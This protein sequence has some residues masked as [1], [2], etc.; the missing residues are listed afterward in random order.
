MRALAA[1]MLD[2]FV[3][4]LPFGLETR[5]G[6]NG[7]LFSGGQRQRLGLARAILRGSHLFLLDEA[8]SALDEENEKQV[9]ANLGSSGRA[10][11]IVTHRV[12]A[13]AFANRVFRLEEGLLRED[14]RPNGLF[15]ELIPAAATS[16]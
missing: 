5:I 1:A 9:L 3:A 15:D 11:L 12:H 2:E 14:V 8:T 7:A 4:T 10:L 6:D 13:Q 16:L